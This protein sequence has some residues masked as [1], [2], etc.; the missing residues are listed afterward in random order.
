MLHGTSQAIQTY[1]MLVYASAG[2]GDV[3]Y[4]W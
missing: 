4:L 1:D 2:V 3:E